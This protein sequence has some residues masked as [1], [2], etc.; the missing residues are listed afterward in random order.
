[1][2]A[3]VFAAVIAAAV[4]HAVWNALVKGSS[5]KALSMGAVALGHLP[6]ALVLM[7]LVPKPDAASLPYLVV[8]I[9][10]HFGYQLFL[11]KSYEVGDL[12]QVYP[13]ARGSAPLLVAAVSFLVLGEPLSATELTAV[14]AIALGI[15]SLSIVRR[16][17]DGSSGHAAVLAVVTG[18]FIASYSIIDGYGARVAGTSLGFY[19]WLALGNAALMAAYLGLWRPQALADMP[20][21]GLRLFLVGGTMSFVAYALV[22]WSFTQAPIALV[23]ALRETSIIIALLIGVVFLNERLSL[24]KLL[25]TLL[26]LF[27]AVLLRWAR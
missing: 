3:Q 10:L 1:M 19:C 7:P 26:T 11:I 20:G 16:R 5:D 17:D 4:M 9:V 12:T 8:G 22:I 15:I 14:A 24:L 21:K 18:V 2:S 13:I 25:S 23:T 27:G 6:L